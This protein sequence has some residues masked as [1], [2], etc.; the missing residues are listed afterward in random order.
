MAERIDLQ[1]A[2]RRLG[3][4]YQTAYRWVREGRLT[5]VRVR[6]RYELAV[7]DIEAFARER[8]Q[9]APA[10][11]RPGRREWGRSASRLLRALS[12]GDE[13]TAIEVVTR[14]HAQGETAIDVLSRVVVP[15]MAGIGDRWASGELS[16][17]HEHRASEIVTRVLA[18]I[19]RP[20]PG[21]PRGT[22]LVT[23]PPGELHG[24]PLDMAAAVLRED[25]WSVQMLGRDMPGDD[26]LE[27]V[28]AVAPDLVV[29]TFTTPERADAAD[30]VARRLT[31]AHHDV[32]V[33]EPGRTL[34]EL[35]QAARVVRAEQRRLL[36]GRPRDE[37]Q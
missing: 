7:E 6:G 24:I 29:L 16:V 9:P 35:V 22:V 33:G 14:L 28:D 19:D 36:A 3:V 20:R 23:A 1:E 4:H 8:D 21:R 32:L 30:E 15:A 26:L 10:S 37:P 13:R 12:E 5:A 27:F 34:A 17:A 2:A 25:G 18:G 11:V 31:G